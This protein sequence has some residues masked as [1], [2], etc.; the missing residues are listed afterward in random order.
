MRQAGTCDVCGLP[1]TSTNRIGVCSRTA[2]CRREY[3]RRYQGRPFRAMPEPCE[4]CGQPV[5][6][7]NTLGVCDRGGP[8]RQEY[9]RRANQCRL[10]SE[11]ND[12]ALLERRRQIARENGSRRYREAVASPSECRP[13]QY[14]PVGCAEPAVPG[15]ILCRGHKRELSAISKLH[16]RN[17]DLERLAAA[18]HGM[19]TWCWRQLPA[20]LRL[21]DVDHVIPRTLGGPDLAWNLACLHRGC[22]VAKSNSIT[23]EAERLAAVHGVVIAAPL[24][25]GRRRAA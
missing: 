4:L 17:G 14:A 16:R 24:P 11:R 21:T 22:N 3:N 18:Q 19:C 7:T 20:E 10:E 2:E 5:G 15:Q 12:P 13:C 25:R 9:N 8:C 23:A 6:W 1:V